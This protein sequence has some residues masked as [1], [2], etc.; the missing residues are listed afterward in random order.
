MIL[1]KVKI[2][3]IVL[4][5]K[6]IIITGSQGKLLI[7]Q[8]QQKNGIN[9]FFNLFQLHTE[10]MENVFSD[11]EIVLKL[12][13]FVQKSGK[14]RKSLGIENSW[15]LFIDIVRLVANPSNILTLFFNCY[16]LY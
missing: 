1:K 9:Y 3:V 7:T 12:R 14:C 10:K 15:E 2:I 8:F 13:I 6:I 4:F 5:K 16:I 11:R